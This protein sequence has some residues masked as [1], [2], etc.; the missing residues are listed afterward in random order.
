[1]LERSYAPGYGNTIRLRHVAEPDLR[2]ARATPGARLQGALLF[3]ISPDCCA[4]DNFEG[5]AVRVEGE[6]VG[7]IGGGV[8]VLLGVLQGDGPEDVDRLATKVAQFRIFSETEVRSKL[9]WKY[10]EGIKRPYFH[11]KPL[12]R[13]Q[14]KNWQDYLDFMK[15]EMAKEGGD[16]TEVEIIYERC[17]IACALYEEFWMDY[18]SWWESRKELEPPEWV[19]SPTQF[20]VV[21]TYSKKSS[22]VDP[23]LAKNRIQ[24][25]VPQMKGDF[26]NSIKLIF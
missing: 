3:E 9:R 6:V 22:D 17:L 25:F 18:V 10:E 24:G 13:G 14:L 4:A 21:T 8:L 19:K 23:V 2:H 26:K 15:V 5:L 7:A 11:V 12:E 1:M 16:L 20:L